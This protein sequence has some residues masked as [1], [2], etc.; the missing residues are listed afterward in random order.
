MKFG[1]VFPQNE[2]GGDLTALRDYTQTIEGLGF[3]HILA[4]D[5][6]LGA[7]P[8]RPG[9]WK[10]PYTYASPFFEPFVL[11]SFMA[12]W[13]QTLNFAT[14]VLVLP[15]RQTA[16]VAKQ[17]AT[18]DV[19]SGG[20][21]RLGVGI[22]WNA[23]EYASLNENFHNRGRRIEEQVVLLRQLWTQPLVDFKGRWHTIPDAG[24][25][26]LPVQ[27]PIPI[28][29]GG[30]AEEVLHRIATL[31]DGWLLPQYENVLATQP[32]LDSLDRF[33]A[34][35]GR[36]RRD[37]GL[38]VRFS[39][40]TGDPV[41]WKKMYKDWESIGTTYLTLSTL[42]LGYSTPGEH[43]RAVQTFAKEMM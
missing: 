23:V 9:G 39:Y 22:G 5:H 15:Q 36:S 10:R 35:A 11:F 26:P 32:L 29:F 38:E 8:N 31:G 27:R 18:L 30:E 2:F 24:I 6:V 34:Q 40:G 19:L 3:N 43:L 14:G 28:W 4:Y 25:N 1:V 21:F 41:A 7:N 42:G 33:L 12:S 37:L 20:R 17:A 13:T 16:L